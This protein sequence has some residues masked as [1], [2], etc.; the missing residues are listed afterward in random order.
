MLKEL[1]PHVPTVVFDIRLGDRLEFID[2]DYQ[3][4]ADVATEHELTPGEI[5]GFTTIYLPAESR[6]FAASDSEGVYEEQK[7]RTSIFVPFSGLFKNDKDK[8]VQCLNDGS[9]WRKGKLHRYLN[10]VTWHEFGHHIEATRRPDG[11]AESASRE[12]RKKSRE[13]SSLLIGGYAIDAVVLSEHPLVGAT[14]VLLLTAWG[15]KARN[16]GVLRY[17]KMK[18]EDKPWEKP[19]IAFQKAYKQHQLVSCIPKQV[20]SVPRSW[21]TLAHKLFEG[22]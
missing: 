22:L 11:E 7:K 9:G 13:I 16:S 21:R 15:A 8:M 2:F 17:R 1:P 4:F 10:R 18:W 12:Y 3:M 19:A 20:E 5:E 14:G 6:G